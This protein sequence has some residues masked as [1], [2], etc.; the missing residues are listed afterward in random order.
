MSVESGS[1]ESTASSTRPGSE[2]HTT[3]GAVPQAAKP[4]QMQISQE[5]QEKREELRKIQQLQQSQQI[6]YPQYQPIQQSQQ[7]PPWDT[8]PAIFSF[9]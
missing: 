6:Q 1:S 8:D 2:K 4:Q 5:L 3:P 9:H 7:M